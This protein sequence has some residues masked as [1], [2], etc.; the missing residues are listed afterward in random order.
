MDKYK[1][2]SRDIWDYIKDLPYMPSR[3]DRESLFNNP[4]KRDRVQLWDYFFRIKPEDVGKPQQ[5]EIEN[6]RKKIAKEITQHNE[7]KE[8]TQTEIVTL[9]TI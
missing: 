7:A 2:Y 1:K 6:I 4:L 8:K 3:K 9:V 5:N